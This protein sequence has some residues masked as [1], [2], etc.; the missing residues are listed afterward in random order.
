MKDR[1]DQEKLYREWMEWL[2]ETNDKENSFP[3]VLATQEGISALKQMMQEMMQSA[4]EKQK[5][6]ESVQSKLN[7]YGRETEQAKDAKKDLEKLLA[8]EKEK[9]DAHLQTV[10]GYE[11]QLVH[12]QN[13]LKEVSVE[14]NAE[15]QEQSKLRDELA[16]S[17][18]RIRELESRWSV[19]LSKKL[20]R[21]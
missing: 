17:Q 14:L 3:D 7:E 21:Y 20:R 4:R 15:K 12:L 9:N 8:E 19:R 13:K 6:A 18:Q 1:N 10:H 11:N 5:Y 16:Q 2:E